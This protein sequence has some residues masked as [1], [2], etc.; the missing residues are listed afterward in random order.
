MK[1]QYSYKICFVPFSAF[2]ACLACLA[3]LASFAFAFSSVNVPLD[4]RVYDM[5]E[6]LEGY[7]LIDSALSG[8]KP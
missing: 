2:L 3:F 5:L 8:T 1:T 4:S 6:R 7:G